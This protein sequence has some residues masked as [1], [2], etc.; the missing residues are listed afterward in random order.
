[1]MLVIVH[2]IWLV[3]NWYS[4]GRTCRSWM[5]T[6]FVELA[7]L[8]SVH[9]L[10]SESSAEYLQTVFRRSVTRDWP[11]ML[12]QLL[13]LTSD[14]LGI[15]HGI[16]LKWIILWS[17]TFANSSSTTSSGGCGNCVFPFIV[18]NRQSDR[19]TSIDGDSPWCA[20]AV[21][22]SGKMTTWEYCQVLLILIN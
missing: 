5:K 6:D 10:Q 1:M 12:I 3:G 17:G 4:R 19:C 20:T 21:D 2:R 18:G 13:L 16:K 7:V 11:A 14:V 9:W 8:H 22:N 15:N